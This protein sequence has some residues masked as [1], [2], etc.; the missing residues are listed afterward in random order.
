MTPTTSLRAAAIA[1]LLLGAWLMWGCGGSEVIGSL[2]GSEVVGKLVTEDSLPVAGARVAAL[3]VTSIDSAGNPRF[4]TAAAV[5][6]DDAGMFKFEKLDEGE[7]FLFASQESD[8]LVLPLTAF[9]PDSTRRIDLG[10]LVMKKLGVIRGTVVTTAGFPEQGIF[11]SVDGTSFIATVNRE[12]GDFIISRIPPDTFYEVTISS[13]GYRS[14]SISQ[15][16]VRPGEITVLDDTI[17][18]VLDPA[19]KP[20]IAPTGLTVVYDTLTGSARLAWNRVPLEDVKRYLVFSIVGD[21][22]T[23]DTV[24]D[25]TDTI[26][27]FSSIDDD[28]AASVTFQIAAFDNDNNEG[29]RGEIDILLAVPPSWL[30]VDIM[31]EKVDGGGTIDSVYVAMSFA[32]RIRSVN[33]ITWWAD[34]PDSV[35]KVAEVDNDTCGSDTLLWI[36]S[37]AVKRLYVTV[38]DNA[39]SA[40]TDSID[41]AS[42]LPI[43]TWQHSD[44][45]LEERRYAGACAVGGKM[46]VFGG[47]REKLTMTGTAS[48]AGIKTAEMYDP[49]SH[50]WSRIAPMNVARLKAAYAVVD[51]MIYVFGGTS[52]TIDH[53]TVERYDPLSDKWEIVDSMRQPLV[54]AAA[55]AAE[56]IIYIT[57][58][59]TGTG[60]NPKL[61]KTILTYDP[62]R[63]EWGTSDDL[64]IARQM[65]QAVAFEQTILVIGG[66]TY[67]E[68]D[69]EMMPLNT[70]ECIPVSSGSSCPP[71]DRNLRTARFGFCAAVAGEK[72]VLIGGL[73][74]AT[75]DEAPVTTVEVSCLGG[76]SSSSGTPMPAAREGSVAVTLDGRIY[77][78]G[79]SESGAGTQK[80][81]RAVYVYFP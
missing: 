80:S 36:I 23:V 27:I 25:T 13:D 59:V 24:A 42:L 22:H 71:I 21:V 39:D 4:D 41:A 2:G 10:I 74:N 49:A 12:T 31:L 29:P 77:V 67:D 5:V 51:G 66:L 64:G 75:V 32:S 6:S 81:T 60:G 26:R 48:L 68:R 53:T 46:Y 17:L 9:Q 61:V 45:L 78:I 50:T 65:H 28:S 43:D 47:C 79:G 69:D 35:V 15:I 57:G 7:Y 62:G 14:V 33:K 30:R 3:A 44:S 73:T 38:I 55:C 11:C 63:K 1:P 8:S 56:G 58:G 18:L 37:P 72:L 54:G 16:P 76:D 34:N 40:W 19:G 52:G 70:I 20:E